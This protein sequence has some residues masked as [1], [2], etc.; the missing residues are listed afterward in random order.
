MRFDLYSL[1][2]KAQRERLFKLSIK[3]AKENL[4][5][6][7]QVS[8]IKE[9][10]GNMISHLRKHADN[11]ER[12]IHP[13][14][15]VCEDQAALLEVQHSQIETLLDELQ[16]LISTN[17]LDELYS[18]FN[19]FISRYLEHIALEEGIQKDLLWKHF[20]DED[21]KGVMQRF[22][23][24]LSPEENMESLEFM[25]PCLSVCEV[26]NMLML[27]KKT[28]SQNIVQKVSLIIERAFSKSEWEEINLPQY[29]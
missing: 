4:S 14:F 26:R 28:D 10:L 8:S 7:V 25:L 16:T 6:S 1:I 18:L 3:I 27:I 11:E 5:E 9:D 21:L 20:S 17:S 12:F 29:P 23:Q 19:R 22:K 24:S 15:H 2:H 13:L